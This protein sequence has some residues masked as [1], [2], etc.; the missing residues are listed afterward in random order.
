MKFEWQTEVTYVYICLP[1]LTEIRTYLCLLF[2]EM[3][4]K[5]TVKQS[6]DEILRIIPS[7]PC[8]IILSSCFKN[9]NWRDYQLTANRDWIN[10]LS[11]HSH[12]AAG[13]WESLYA[14][15][16][17]ACLFRKI[18]F[19]LHYCKKSYSTWSLG[20]TIKALKQL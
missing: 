1:L 17:G 20:N 18:S 11:P 3:K 12:S 6:Y 13:K 14:P 8:E 2:F 15:G 5:I 19:S 10:D 4:M 7:N 9:K 16:L